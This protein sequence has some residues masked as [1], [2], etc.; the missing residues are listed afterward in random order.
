[1]NHYRSILNGAQVILSWPG[2]ADVAQV[3]VPDDWPPG[4]LACA[5]DVAG[6]PDL[7]VVGVADPRVLIDLTWG[8]GRAL[9]KATIDAGQAFTLQASSATVRARAVGVPLALANPVPVAVSF[10]AGHASSSSSDGVTFTDDPHDVAR[11]ATSP[12]W[13]VPPLAREL[14]VFTSYD[15]TLNLNLYR[16]QWC[17]YNAAGALVPYLEQMSGGGNPGVGTPV[18]DLNNNRLRVPKGAQAMQIVNGGTATTFQPQ[19]R[20]SL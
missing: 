2:A 1:M 14:C 9:L 16:V 18:Y 20:L 19:W 17:S 11:S 10:Y 8:N 3:R 4:V 15:Q 6:F 7:P 12:A 5:T 13:L